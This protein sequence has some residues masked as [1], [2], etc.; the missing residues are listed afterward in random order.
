MTRLARTAHAKLNLALHL[1]R[2]RA[3][4]Y[5]EIETLFAFCEDGDRV[6]VARADD[7]T[8]QVTGPFGDAIGGGDNLVL[9]AARA[10]RPEGAPGAAILLDKRLPVASGLGG[11]SA[12]AAATLLLLR[13]LWQL[14]LDDGA[15]DGVAL[16]L[17]ADV[18]ACLRA[19]LCRGEGIGERLVPVAA[20]GL[21]R[22]PVLLVNPGVALSTAAVFA[23]WDGI[24]RGPLAAVDPW[25]AALAG[26][27]DL[28][29]PAIAL[30]PRIADVLSALSV[31]P[32]ATLVRMSG[33][34]ATCF[35]L[36]DDEGDCAAATASIAS[37][38]PGWW[39]LPTRLRG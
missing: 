21:A 2:R 31:Q 24:D 23:G 37:A 27:N 16:S 17:G 20:G 30:R 3:D 10:I 28:A 38:E 39:V 5:H 4:G 34:G 6:E 11:G 29:S 26:R 8:L 33:S 18:P 32:G 13:D 19:T 35:A 36:F 12:D 1:R 7:L 9:R 15:L 25:P 14:D 22:R